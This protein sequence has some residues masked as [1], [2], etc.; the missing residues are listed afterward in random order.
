MHQFCSVERTRERKQRILW[1]LYSIPEQIR[2]NVRGRDKP[3]DTEDDIGFVQ[4]FR[5]LTCYQKTI[6]PFGS[7]WYSWVPQNSLHPAKHKSIK[8]LVS[9]VPKSP[10][11]LCAYTIKYGIISGISVRNLFSGSPQIIFEACSNHQNHSTLY[12]YCFH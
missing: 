5:R 12:L 4:R 7:G 1:G 10:H 3:N 8:S 11:Y 6:L 2:S 9:V